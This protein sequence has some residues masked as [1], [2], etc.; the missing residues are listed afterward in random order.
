MGGA[1]IG[2]DVQ[3]IRLRADHYNLG[4][5]LAKYAGRYLVCSTMGVDDQLEAGEESV[6]VGTLLLQN[7]M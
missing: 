6:L 2:I 3:P 7:S 5:Q 1:D 4:S